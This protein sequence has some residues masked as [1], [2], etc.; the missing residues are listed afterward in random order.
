MCTKGMRLSLHKLTGW[1]RRFYTR[2]GHRQSHPG[3]QNSKKS[4]LSYNKKL[5]SRSSSDTETEC[6]RHHHTIVEASTMA[7]HVIESDSPTRTRIGIPDSEE[8][9][10]MVAELP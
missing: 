7:P 10:R 5:E 1:L 3:G 4:D 6:V 8:Y 2:N 9:D